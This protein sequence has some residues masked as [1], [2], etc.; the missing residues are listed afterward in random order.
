MDEIN[1]T[2]EKKINYLVALI[3]E[4]GVGKTR[5]FRIIKN[6]EYIT[7]SFWN[8]EVEIYNADHYKLIDTMGLE[9]FFNVP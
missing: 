3:G 9:R 6:E 5:F 7:K 8:M 1:K 4:S 2:E